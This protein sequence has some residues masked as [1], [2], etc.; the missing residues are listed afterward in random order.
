MIEKE[1]FSVN[2][3]YFK[4]MVFQ[5]PNWDFHK[6]DVD[7]DTKKAIAET[8]KYVD[9]NNPDLR[10]LKKAGGKL[11]IVSSWN[12]LALPPR[13]VAEYY[14]SVEKLMGGPAQTQD[15]A[16]LFSIPG[17][18]GCVVGP[19]FKALEAMQEWVEKG[20]APDQITYSYSEGGRGGKVN[21]TRPVCAYPKVSK[22]KGS[23]DINDA[24]NFTCVSPVK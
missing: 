5:D 21:R 10:S 4:G 1:P 23:G 22:Y 7:R 8:A 19:N 14:K 9:G 20:T 18:D 17:A 12:S 15:F 24:A 3:N 16:R 6:Y 13:Q 11:I 2:I